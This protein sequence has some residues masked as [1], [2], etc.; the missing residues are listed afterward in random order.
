M[1]LDPALFTLDFAKLK[2]ST[3][4][5]SHMTELRHSDWSKFSVE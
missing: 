5:S 1:Y 3:N 4:Q 2:I